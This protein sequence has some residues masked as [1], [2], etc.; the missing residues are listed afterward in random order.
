MKEISIAW[1]VLINEIRSKRF[2]V[3]QFDAYERKLRVE[4]L[5]TISRLM[6]NISQPRYAQFAAVNLPVEFVRFACF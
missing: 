3:E 4:S 2:Q 6:E 1:P 5:G